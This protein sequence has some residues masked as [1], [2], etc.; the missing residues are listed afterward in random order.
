MLYLE[1]ARP[2]LAL[3]HGERALDIP[4]GPATTRTYATP[5]R[6]P[7]HTCADALA[8]LNDVNDPRLRPAREPLLA[9][10]RMLV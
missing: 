4:A 7:R 1:T 5:L 9:V 6:H 3:H 10:K 8:V 2:D